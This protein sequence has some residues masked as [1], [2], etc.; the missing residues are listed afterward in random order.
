MGE[1]NNTDTNGCHDQPLYANIKN[2]QG[3]TADLHDLPKFSG[4]TE[5]WPLFKRSFDDS[6]SLSQYNNLQ[7][8]MRLRKCLV[9]EAKEAKMYIFP[10]EKGC[11]FT[12]PLWTKSIRFY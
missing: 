8:L 12:S 1:E 6:K 10:M 5:E 11:R 3:S 4:N 2:L 7:K 9:G